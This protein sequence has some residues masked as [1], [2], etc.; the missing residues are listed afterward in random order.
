ME[1]MKQSNQSPKKDLSA[2]P[3]LTQVENNTTLWIGH[4]QTDPTDHFAGQ[5]FKCPS[6]GQLDNIQ[7]YSSTVHQPGHVVLTMHEFDVNTKTWGPAIGN[8]TLELKRNDTGKWIR[9]NLQPVPLYK[10]ATYGFRLQTTDALIGIGE[11]AT[12]TKQPFTF[13]HEWNGDSKNLIG[14]FFSYFSLAFKVELCA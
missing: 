2:R 4:L 6:A 7:V 8:S 11:A 5:T 9:F 14:H 12:G 3:V 1:T 10:D 13:G